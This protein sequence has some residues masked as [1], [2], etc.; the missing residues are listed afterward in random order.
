MK[1]LFNNILIKIEKAENVTS[2][3]I[4][5]ANDTDKKLERAVAV[6]VGDEVLKV[7]VDDTIIFKD[8]NADTITIDK[9][10]FSFIKEEHILAT[11]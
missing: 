6:A 1:P 4:F 3:G 10:E 9:Q 7:K 5:I 11:L 2:S 8:Y